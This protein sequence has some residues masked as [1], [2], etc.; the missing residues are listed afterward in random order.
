[1]NRKPLALL[2]VLLIAGLAP[3]AAII[4]FCARMPC[5]RHAPAA[6]L[7]FSTGGRD[8]CTSVTCYD[9][10]SAKLTAGAAASA[11]AAVPA[12]R[13]TTAVFQ[14]APVALRPFIDTSPPRDAGDRLAVLSILLI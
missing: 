6:P 8:C 9:A 14:P 1:M 2:I 4:G 5:C 11:L 10:P 13:S 7:A 3:A 12:L